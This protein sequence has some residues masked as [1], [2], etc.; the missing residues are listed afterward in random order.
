[1]KK[2]NFSLVIMAVAFLTSCGTKM[3]QKTNA[4]AEENSMEKESD[5]KKPIPFNVS[6]IK[7]RSLSEGEIKLL[8]FYN[9]EEITLSLEE[10]HNGTSI[11]DGMLL[12][13][14]SSN[15]ETNKVSRLTLGRAIGFSYDTKRQGICIS[16]SKSNQL[17]Q[18]WYLMDKST[19]E[20]I[21]DGWTGG[22]IT[23][24]GQKYIIR[25][26]GDT[27]NKLLFV[28]DQKTVVEKS[29]GKAEGDPVN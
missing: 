15:I 13:L 21:L 26:S 27:P 5:T 22:K 18:L 28:K 9:S 7:K 29:S 4:P 12:A 6:Y 24:N 16:F 1:M 14:D 11:E 20:F 3:P 10:S 23:R 17:Y 25:S 8:Q 2:V 19:G